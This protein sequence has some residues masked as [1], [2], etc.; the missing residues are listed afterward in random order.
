MKVGKQFLAPTF[1]IAVLVALLILIGWLAFLFFDSLVTKAVDVEP[2]FAVTTSA[3]ER[4]SMRPAQSRE[5][6]VLAPQVEPPIP[7]VADPR[8]APPGITDDTPTSPA[9]CIHYGEAITSRPA[10]HNPLEIT[11]G[12]LP[13]VVTV[14]VMTP[15]STEEVSP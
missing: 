8:S 4:V 1:V 15:A 7:H 6:I 5:D 13:N 12:I 11:A 2:F 3:V 14:Q 9:A 10:W